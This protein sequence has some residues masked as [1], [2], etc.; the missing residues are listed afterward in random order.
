[1]NIPYDSIVKS[2]ESYKADISQF[3]RDMIKIPSESCNEEEVVLRIKE[4]MLKVG[5]DRVEID[6]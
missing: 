6:P 3:L 1:M 4:E 5:F 2:V